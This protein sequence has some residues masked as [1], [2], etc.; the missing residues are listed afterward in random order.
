MSIPQSVFLTANLILVGAV[1]SKTAQQLVPMVFV[2]RGVRKKLE[3]NS[4]YCP[5]EL[6]GVPKTANMVAPRV[7][8]CA[9][10]KFKSIL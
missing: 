8:V 7:P 1:I 3:N 4:E 2:V 9:N 10:E 6:F 5:G